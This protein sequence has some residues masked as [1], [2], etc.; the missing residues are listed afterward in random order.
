[1]TSCRQ[2][3]AA[4][5]SKIQTQSEV[6]TEHEATIEGLKAQLAGMHGSRQQDD[7]QVEVPVSVPNT[8]ESA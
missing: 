2:Q 4:A 7:P 8:A 3:L 5:R 1:M 6:I